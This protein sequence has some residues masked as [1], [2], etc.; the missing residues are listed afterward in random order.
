MESKSIEEDLAAYSVNEEALQIAYKE[1]KKAHCNRLRQVNKTR[2]LLR[3]LRKEVE[4]LQP[5]VI[6]LGQKRS[7]CV[8]QL[9]EARRTQSKNRS[10]T[11][12][13][14]EEIKNLQRNLDELKEAQTDF[15]EQL[16]R[17]TG[18]DTKKVVI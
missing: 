10:K 2:E 13:K 7:F 5:K 3:S 14:E 1:K 17:Q 11:V 6:Q 8:K 12:K 16:R 15:E 9:E 4:R 18:S